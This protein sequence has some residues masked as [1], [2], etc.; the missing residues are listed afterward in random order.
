METLQVGSPRIAAVVDMALYSRRLPE[1][2]G[3]HWV[4]GTPDGGEL[5][6]NLSEVAV[7]RTQTEW[8]QLRQRGKGAVIVVEGRLVFR[9]KELWIGEAAIHC[10]PV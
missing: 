1:A 3:T 7:A 10:R 6:V 4:L 8:E 5:H 2:D 9:R